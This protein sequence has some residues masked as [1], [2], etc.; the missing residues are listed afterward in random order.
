MS[1]LKATGNCRKSFVFLQD[2]GT[3]SCGGKKAEKKLIGQK[4]RSVQERRTELY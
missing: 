2:M 3:G 1:Y 4:G